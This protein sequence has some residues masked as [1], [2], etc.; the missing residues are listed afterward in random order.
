LAAIQLTYKHLGVTV[1]QSQDIAVAECYLDAYSHSTRPVITLLGGITVFF[2]AGSTYVEAGATAVDETDGDITA[3][4]LTTGSV[5]ATLEGM[6]TVT[7]NVADLK[8]HPA[9]PVTRTVIVTPDVTPPVISLIG[10]EELLLWNYPYE[11]Y[12]ELGA[13]ATDTVDGTVDT[14]TTGTVDTSTQG[15]YTVTYTA[16][17]SADNAATPVTRTVVVQHRY[18]RA[19]IGLPTLT[20]NGLGITADDKPGKEGMAL[21]GDGNTIA[22]A[23]PFE[24]PDGKVIVHQYQAGSFADITQYGSKFYANNTVWQTAVTDYYDTNLNDYY[25]APTYY[26][27]T[28]VDWNWRG[29]DVFALGSSKDMRGVNGTNNYVDFWYDSS[30][31]TNDFAYAGDG[32]HGPL[33]NGNNSYGD[34]GIVAAMLGDGNVG[35]HYMENQLGYAM[36]MDDVGRRAVFTHPGAGDN[37]TGVIQIYEEGTNRWTHQS[38]TIYG[39]DYA[40]A[41]YDVQMSGDGYSIV[42]SGGYGQNVQVYTDP[43]TSALLPSPNVWTAKGTSV[44][45][46]D[47]SNAVDINYDGSV[48]VMSIAAPDSWYS[49]PS[50]GGVTVYKYGS[51]WEQVGTITPQG[52]FSSIW[53]WSVAINGAG[54]VV[55][56]GDP[57]HFGD[58]ADRWTGGVQ[59]FEKLD[60]VDSWAQRGSTITN[61]TT[62]ALGAYVDLDSSGNRLI[63][64]ATLGDGTV[65]K[66]YVYEWD[67]ADWL[68]IASFD[69]AATY[70]LGWSEQIAPCAISASGQTVIVSDLV[71]TSFPAKNAGLS[72]HKITSAE[73]PGTWQRLPD[74]VP[75]SGTWSSGPAYRTFARDKDPQYG[76]P[77]TDSESAISL[78]NDGTVL[79]VTCWR[80]ATRMYKLDGGA[81]LE[82]GVLDPFNGAGFYNDYP[83]NSALSRDGLSV[84]VSN[85]SIDE[86]GT[87]AGA[88][89]VYE[90]DGSGWAQ[91]GVNFYA[92]PKNYNGVRAAISGD[93]TV[94]GLSN[95]MRDVGPDY[96][97]VSQWDGAA[98]VPL[99]DVIE[100]G[101]DFDFA[102]SDNSGYT[103]ALSYDG[104]TA[105]IGFANSEARGVP[106]EAIYGGVVEVYNFNGTQW[107]QMG[108]RIDDNADWSSDSVGISTDIS[109]DG[110][111]IIV[112]SKSMPYGFPGVVPAPPD[113]RTRGR[114]QVF[115]FDGTDWVRQGPSELVGETGDYMGAQ[116]AMSADASRVAYNVPAIYGGT[117][118]P[119]K[120]L[121]HIKDF[122]DLL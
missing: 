91:K 63:V 86:F 101:P 31:P 81:W 20:K 66:Y 65:G 57:N 110:L 73:I 24:A 105:V 21:S 76:N 80:E 98:W 112:G 115:K 1:E 19:P 49:F 85:S 50:D 83:R 48:F 100:L 30:D 59:V 79:C 29:Y 15:T 96:V 93:G 99:G 27:N 16:T 54:N 53:G 68:Q 95:Q 14:V 23:A 12:V 74:V 88:A 70:E 118:D 46:V 113:E 34:F 84:V 78:S 94:V 40:M 75:Q 3:N 103:C 102:G 18:W 108:S 77:N 37:M 117:P 9:R 89:A 47:G 32:V 119:D 61:N 13:T 4:I 25:V 45:S 35:E 10:D 107:V 116:V 44:S 51:D 82:T 52:Q 106:G 62:D 97:A 60:G 28:A 109:D 39:V 90:W 122:H 71:Q 67:G 114:A 5:D 17:D 7:Y 42:F 36:S 26:N 58:T 43:Q 8:G 72:V 121:I 120:I 41:G 55:A 33:E 6:Y 22:L 69:A 87:N 64:A 11:E 104:L 56:V 111:T 92:G 2:E 38:P